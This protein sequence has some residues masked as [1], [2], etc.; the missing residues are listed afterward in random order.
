MSFFEQVIAFLEQAHALQ[1][2]GLLIGLL[3][4]IVI[5]SMIKHYLIKRLKSKFFKEWEIGCL[6]LSIARHTYSF[7]V[8]ILLFA[9]IGQFID[10]PKEWQSTF[11]HTFVVALLMQIGFWVVTA[12]IFAVNY[13]FYYRAAREGKSIEDD[14]SLNT[15]KHIIG[16]IIY[17]L[18]WST[19]L[20][21]CLDNIGFNV[22][23]IVAGL[24]IGGIAIGLAVQNILGDLLSSLSILFDKPFVKGDFIIVGD[25]LGTIERIGLKTTR[26]RS[27][28]GELIVFPNK[29]LVE[30]QI[31]NYQ[32][33]QERRI[34][35]QIGVIYETSADQLAKIPQIIKE[36][37]EST[38]L[39][40]FDRSHFAKY[41]DFSLDF[42]TVYYVLS[43]DYGQYM[44]VQQL[45]NIK[46]FKAFEEE[47]IV[48]AYPTQQ[49]YLTS[50]K[51]SD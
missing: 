41:G 42:E 34:V 28:S 1:V 17:L 4:G 18:I 10:L 19:I 5:F 39:A 11:H 46:L 16:F 44:D 25:Y 36:I 14:P 6:I 2:T 26:V 51:D 29:H 47:G 21:L 23:S 9:G 35:F 48:F 30:S 40:R 31:R 45:I 33:M 27:L 37:I 50:T 49:L 12:S 20:L 32:Q 7:L 3:I 38:A 13:A 43:S 22:T 8:L 24:G 15:G